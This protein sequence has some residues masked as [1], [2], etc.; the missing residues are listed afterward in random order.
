MV[1]VLV[2]HKIMFV[3]ILSLFYLVHVQFGDRVMRFNFDFFGLLAKQWLTYF[4]VD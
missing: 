4:F 1:K 3:L 2:L